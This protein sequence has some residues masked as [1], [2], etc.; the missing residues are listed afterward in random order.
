PTRPPTRSGDYTL[1]REEPDKLIAHK[2]GETG[3]V[4]HDVGYFL[5]PGY[6]SAVVVLTEVTNSSGFDDTMARG[7][8]VVQEIGLAIYSYLEAL[9][10]VDETPTPEPTEE[11]TEEPSEG[12]TDGEP[13]SAGGGAG[14]SGSGTGGG[15]AVS[16]SGASGGLPNTGVSTAALTVALTALLAGTAVTVFARRRRPVHVMTGRRVPGL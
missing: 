13:T 3:N 7:N 6:E 4:T 14:S 12:P 1:D 10:D 5:V 11:P 15:S 9:A 2:T 16:G 8:P